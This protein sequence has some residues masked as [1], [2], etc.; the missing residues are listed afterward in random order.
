[1]S[2]NKHR[3]VMDYLISAHGPLINGTIRR[4]KD[5][6]PHLQG[7]DHG[8]L[9]ESAVNALMTAVAHH[10]P[11]MGAS[12]ST[13]ASQKMG[14]AML[15]RFKGGDVSSADRALASKL[16]PTGEGRE[17]DIQTMG[18][19]LDRAAIESAG[20]SVSED[21]GPSGVSVI[22]NEAADFARQN[23]HAISAIQAKVDKYDRQQAAKQP[24]VAVPEVKQEVEKPKS[25]QIIIRRKQIESNLGPEQKD[26]MTRVDALKGGQ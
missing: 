19:K 6:Y 25:P 16:R 4:M 2:D 8:D 23:P 9:H 24:Q 15:Q 13:Y 1:M 10:D 17:Q 7:A 18:G 21:G 20:G 26:R 11:A 5:K 22:R 12:L 3:E 14:K